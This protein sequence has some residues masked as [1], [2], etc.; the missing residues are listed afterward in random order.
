MAANTFEVKFITMNELK[1]RTNLKCSGCVAKVK[2]ALESIESLN[3]WNVDI[4][5]PDKVLTVEGE[6]VSGSEV[7][8]ALKSAGY[9]GASI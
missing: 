1:F 4:E 2:P 7:I 9:E 3:H 5:S 6:G 8:N